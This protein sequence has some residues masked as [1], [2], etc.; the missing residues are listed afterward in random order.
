G[1]TGRTVALEKI[2]GLLCRW[3]Y[4]VLC[5][6]WD[7]EAPGLHLYYD[8]WITSRRAG[9]TELIQAHIEGDKP[10]LKNFLTKVQFPDTKLPLRLLTAGRQDRTYVER[11]QE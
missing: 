8:P 7:L 3:G 6:D 10:A 4:R 11:M 5:I 1:G 2:S 9:L